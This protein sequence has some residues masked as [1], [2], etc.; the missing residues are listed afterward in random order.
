MVR[1]WML[2]NRI[3]AQL[4]HE[5]EE[6]L[7][8]GRDPDVPISGSLA[9]AIQIVRE[10]HGGDAALASSLEY[11]AAMATLQQFTERVFAERGPLDWISKW[12]PPRV[13]F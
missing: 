5:R 3:D 13:H 4:E 2:R 9:S 11:L 10:C 1:K 8:L 12:H 6:S 7:R